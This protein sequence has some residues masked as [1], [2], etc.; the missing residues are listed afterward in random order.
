MRDLS[1]VI[2]EM[3]SIVP[4]TEE[5]LIGRLK[6]NLE[7]AL[8]SAPEVIGR[9]WNEVYHTLTEELFDGNINMDWKLK[10]L[11][12]FSTKPIDQLKEELNINE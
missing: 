3:L 2:E 6:D 1:E 4:N 12:I 10:V 5:R 7:S 8:Y 9:W 11:S